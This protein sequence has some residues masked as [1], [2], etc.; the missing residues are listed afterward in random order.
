MISCPA[1]S[2]AKSSRCPSAGTPFG[3]RTRLARH[4]FTQRDYPAVRF[5]AMSVFPPPEFGAECALAARFSHRGLKTVHLLGSRASRADEKAAILKHH[6][7]WFAG[8]G[9]WL[10]GVTRREITRNVAHP[11]QECALSACYTQALNSL[12]SAQTGPNISAH[13]KPV[14]IRRFSCP[15]GPNISAHGKPVAIRRFFLPRR[16]TTYQ[17]RASGAPPWGW[18]KSYPAAL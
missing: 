11:T 12:A 6:C 2:D 10:S 5:A 4:L 9:D 18:R 15:E 17:P 8:N 14:A 3:A 16:G 7:A 13:G 1:R